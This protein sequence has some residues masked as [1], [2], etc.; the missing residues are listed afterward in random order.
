MPCTNL[1]CTPSYSGAGRGEC[2]Q[3]GE[4]ELTSSS[5]PVNWLWLYGKATNWRNGQVLFTRWI[6]RPPPPTH[7][8][9]T[10][11][12]LLCGCT[13]RQS[14]GLDRS[15][16]S[17]QCC[18]AGGRAGERAGVNAAAG[19]TA[20]GC[21]SGSHPARC[22]RGDAAGAATPLL[23]LPLSCAASHRGTRRG[24]MCSSGKQAQQQ[25]P[26]FSI[27][28]FHTGRWGLF[29][30]SVLLLGFYPFFSPFNESV[31]RWK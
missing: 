25:S 10:G 1:R 29:P 5:Y 14:R 27:C 12:N 31:P 9:A 23:H 4:P 2:Q 28:S 13:A 19:S 3:S 20:A 7:R 26:S 8:A 18:C 17:V 22:R 15:E 24:S 30:P 21:A 6:P 16:S 11:P